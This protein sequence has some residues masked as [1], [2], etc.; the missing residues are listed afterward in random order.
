MSFV[1]K[2]KRVVKPE[3][4]PE[5]DLGVFRLRDW[6]QPN[7][8]AV[9]KEV[10]DKVMERWFSLS[11]E[12]QDY[13]IRNVGFG[14]AL[15]KL[16]WNVVNTEIRY[17]YDWDLFNQ[18]DFWMFPSETW[19]MRFGDCEDTTM[20]LASAVLRLFEVVNDFQLSWVRR[21]FTRDAP[22]CYAC[23]GFFRGLDAPYGH[24][25]VMFKNPKHQFSKDWLVL[26]TTLENEVPL[27]LWILWSKDA[28]VP[29]YLF[30]DYDMLR[31]DRDYGKLGLEKDYVERYKTLIDAMIN[32]VEAG[33]P[34]PQKWVHKTIRPVKAEFREV[35]GRRFV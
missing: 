2:R 17:R 23:I 31:I 30:N 13:A 10:I 21:W 25:W 29:V 28:Y 11:A 6:I 35:K 33:V 22:V 5:V 19:A 15:V 12:E 4:K 3:G 8:Y 34:T 20:L 1:T 32:Y 9:A 27:Y 24:A 7:C 18:A 14:N 26:E 16:A